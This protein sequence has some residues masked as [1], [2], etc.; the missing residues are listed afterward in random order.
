MKKG[1]VAASPFD[2]R[3]LVVE[4]PTVRVETP[5]GLEVDCAM[6]PDLRV[7]EKRWREMRRMARQQLGYSIV[8]RLRRR[9]G[10]VESN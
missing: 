3:R 1:L 6:P 5:E 2:R 9:S 7:E 10:E 8:G 4:V